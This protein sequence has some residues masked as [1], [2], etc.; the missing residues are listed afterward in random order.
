MHKLAEYLKES[1]SEDVELEFYQGKQG[2][3]MAYEQ[4]LKADK[5]YSFADL[6]RYYKVFPP[7]PKSMEVW[8]KASEN[9]SKRETW[10]ILVDTP[11]ARKVAARHLERYSVKFLPKRQKIKGF[12]FVDVIIFDDNIAII[13]LSKDLPTATVITS[14]EIASTLRVVHQTTW[15]LLPPIED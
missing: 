11:I 10:D 12:G 13:N 8:T 9:N 3:M 2:V 5:V 6:D 15:S 1:T 4:V 14:S 7:F